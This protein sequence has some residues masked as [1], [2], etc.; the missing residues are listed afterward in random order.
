LN[1]IDL[2]TLSAD[3]SRESLLLLLWFLIIRKITF[4]LKKQS[5]ES[6]QVKSSSKI[7]KNFPKK[8]FGGTRLDLMCFLI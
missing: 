7:L 2:K 3:K 5:K 1:F 8:A 6:S 4:A